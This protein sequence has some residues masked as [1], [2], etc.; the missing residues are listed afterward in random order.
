V[1]NA[2]HAS[3]SI[4]GVPLVRDVSVHV[5]PGQVTAIMGPNGAGKSTLLRLLAG[6]V[7]ANSGGVTLD[8]QA[9]EN[10][11]IVER[12]RRRAVVPQRSSIAFGFTVLETVLIGRYPHGGDQARTTDIRIA[13][14]SLVRAG[15]A[16]FESR[17][18]PTLS[19]GELA[20][21]MLARALAQIDGCTGPRYLLLDEPTGALDPAHQHHVMRLLRE[22]AN[23]EEV[24]VLIILHDLNLAARYADEIVFLR[25]GSI[26]ARGSPEN[27]LTPALIAATFDV[28]ALIVAHPSG[29]QPVIVVNG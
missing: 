2:E 22:M 23:K 13:R 5:Q 15:V 28:E 19:G 6:D 18:M 17:L 7:Q 27:V 11:S 14:Q 16:A 21:V 12:A 25:D 20:R 3:L 10:V 1:L 24:G 8:G 9:L 26:T 29:L 4:D